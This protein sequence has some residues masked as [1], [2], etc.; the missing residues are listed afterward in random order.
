M[1]TIPLTVLATFGLLLAATLG[2]WIRPAVWIT[3]LVAA[4]A[5]GYALN[6]LVGP[7]LVW[8]VLLAVACWFYRHRKSSNV[9]LNRVG[10]IVTA[11]AILVLSFLL[12][13]HA[14]PGFHNPALVKQLV[15]SEGAAPYTRYLNFDKIIVGILLLGLVYQGL[16]RTRQGWMEAGR[17]AA[18]LVLANIAIVVLLAFLLGYVTFDPKWTS[19]FWIW[20]VTN[21]FFTCVSEEAFFRGFIQREISST[22]KSYRYGTAVAVTTSAVLFGL[23][24]FSGGWNYVLLSMVAGLG[25]ALVFQ[26]SGRIE[27]AIF[28]HFSLNAFHFLFLTYPRLT[29]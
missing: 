27:M 10:R 15:I 26:R 11:L 22:L 25:Y 8:I 21:L 9:T 20:A 7:A 14:L 19:F 4:I 1:P 23:A 5:L 16:M 18:P 29:Q 12:G 28:A 13:S 24:H 6:V 17:R 3:A 2:L